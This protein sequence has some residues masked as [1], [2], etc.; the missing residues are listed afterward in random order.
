MHSRILFFHELNLP[1]LDG[2][3]VG[4]WVTYSKDDGMVY[5]LNG[6]RCELA[7]LSEI[8]IYKDIHFDTEADCHTAAMA[9][10]NNYNKP[11]PYTKEW[12]EC[13]PLP[14]LTFDDGDV[15]SRTMEFI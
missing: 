3:R 4:Q 7:D 11:Y 10:Y 1:H 12:L 9:Y 13:T 2:D 14:D 5:L 15:G 8:D 6:G